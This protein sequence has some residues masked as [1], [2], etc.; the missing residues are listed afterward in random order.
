MR[1][2]LAIKAKSP[3]KSKTHFH[4]PYNSRWWKCA[5]LEQVTRVELA[6]NSLGSCRHTARR[7]LHFFRALSSFSLNAPIISVFQGIVNAFYPLPKIFTRGFYRT[8]CIPR[9]CRKTLRYT[10]KLQNRYP[11]S[12]SSRALSS[13]P[14]SRPQRGHNT[15]NARGNAAL[16]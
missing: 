4:I 11:S 10:P 15:H 2:P 1:K 13:L 8:S 5:W 14:L 9:T 7:H 12:P 16:R 6:G 3:L